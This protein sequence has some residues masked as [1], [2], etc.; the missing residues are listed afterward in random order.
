MSVKSI[1]FYAF[2]KSVEFFFNDK[3]GI[4]Q[5]DFDMGGET[6]EV[7][8]YQ[9]PVNYPLFADFNVKILSKS[10]QVFH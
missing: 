7:I 8:N 2:P 5:E 6:L 3:Y 10:N 1:F 4:L 9:I